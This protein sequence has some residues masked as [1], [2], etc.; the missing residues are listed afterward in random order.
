MLDAFGDW[1]LERDVGWKR[2]VTELVGPSM[3]ENVGQVDD[4]KAMACGN[5]W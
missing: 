2:W 3:E 1:L 4:L 5:S